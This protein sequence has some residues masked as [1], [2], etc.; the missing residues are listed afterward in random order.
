M[1]PLNPGWDMRWMDAIGA[2]D[3]DAITH[4]REDSIARE[5]GLSAHESKTWL[6]ARAALPAERLPC[7]L[8]WYRA[9]PEFIAGFGLMFCRSADETER[10]FA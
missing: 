1:K 7:P 5:A 10:R 2:G 6:V 3:L 4:L 9:I 8:R